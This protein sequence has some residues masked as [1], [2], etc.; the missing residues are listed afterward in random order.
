MKKIVKKTMKCQFPP[1]QA[2]AVLK[3][4]E[5]GGKVGFKNL[6]AIHPVYNVCII[7]VF[8]LCNEIIR[9]KH[10][11]NSPIAVARHCRKIFCIQLPVPS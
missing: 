4:T 1:L 5:R 3:M 10:N 9:I 11:T 7:R 6:C 2:P 8:P